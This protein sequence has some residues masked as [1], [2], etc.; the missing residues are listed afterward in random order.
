MSNSLAK[1]SFT[2]L[3]H[4]EATKNGKVHELR[5]KNTIGNSQLCF[6]KQ[7]YIQKGYTRNK[8]TGKVRKPTTYVLPIRKQQ[9]YFCFIASL[10][11]GKK[12]KDKL[13]QQ[14]AKTLQL[15]IAWKYGAQQFT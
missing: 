13:E 6:L 14:D 8:L 11:E 1:C 5:C 12:N 7:K 2:W 15:Y 4:L 10:T 9:V 3:L